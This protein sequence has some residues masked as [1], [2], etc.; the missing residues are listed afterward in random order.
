MRQR[1]HI[2]Q[3]QLIAWADAQAG[4]IP[5]L[6]LL[7]AIPNGGARHKAVAG[8]LRAEGVRAGVPD[9]FLPVARGGYHGLFIEMKS[10]E[11]QRRD[12]RPKSGTFTDAQTRWHARLRAQG[13]GVWVC[14]G[15][16]DAQHTIQNYLRGSQ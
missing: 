12:G 3:R 5:E 11:R 13:Y 14:Y 10:P 1:E 4:A 2:E 15:F 8:K 9:L 6:E 16:E 7:F